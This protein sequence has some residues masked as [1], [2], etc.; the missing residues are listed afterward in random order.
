MEKRGIILQVYLLILA[1]NQ[2]DIILLSAVR[3]DRVVIGLLLAILAAKDV[4]G[5]MSN[6]IELI[7]FFS[8]HSDSLF[9]NVYFQFKIINI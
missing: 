1:M 9:T 5:I 3:I 4:N 6:L 7:Y 8:S 2:W